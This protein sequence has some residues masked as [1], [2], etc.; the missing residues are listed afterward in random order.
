MTTG[1]DTIAAPATPPG[2]SA[3]AVIRVSGP[4]AV[5]V[6]ASRFD[7]CNL[8]EAESHTAS[9]GWLLDARGER[10]DQVVVTLFRAPRSATGENV[11][12]I[13]CHGGDAARQ[14]ILR[15]LLNAG[16]RMAEPGEFTQRAFLHGKLDLAQAEAVADLIHAESDLARRVAAAQLEGRTSDVL[17]TVREALLQTTALVELE[18]DFGEEDVEFADRER[19]LRL[20][21]DV[22]NHLT[23]LLDS[24]RLGALVRE[25]VRVVIGG[26]P[27]AGKSTLLNALLERDRAIVSDTPGTTRDALEAEREIGGLRVR[28]VDTAGLRET[29]NAIEA[30]GVRRSR[31]AIEHADALVYVVDVTRGLDVDE[32][33]FV[34]RLVVERK[35]LPVLLVLNK[36]DRVSGDAARAG[37]SSEVWATLSLSAQRALSEPM[38]LRPLRDALLEAIGASRPEQES[39][40]IAVNERHRNHLDRARRAVRR[41]R[42]AVVSNHGG[43]TLALDL[44]TARHELGA[45]TGEVTTEDVLGAIFSQFC[46]GK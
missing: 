38:H 23:D 29:A 40:P 4:E 2:R 8:H 16:A 17:R 3:L 35:D 10:L 21:T 39:A 45:I 13:S 33:A 32:E 11:T 12:E 36:I 15:S 7:G 28:L 26:R 43:D 46:I 6:V 22:D 31:A 14:A 41:A 34:A 24:A 44:R 42:R 37:A 30:E 5:S 18:L 1:A 27:N 19:L 9:V 25:G 20:L